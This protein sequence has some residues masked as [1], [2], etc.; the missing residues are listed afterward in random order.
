M[1]WT[2][3]VLLALAVG[4]SPFL[5]I[6]LYGT[7]PGLVRSQQEPSPI[8]TALG[9]KIKR[10][11]VYHQ[12]WVQ[13]GDTLLELDASDLI[14]KQKQLTLWMRENQWEIQDLT[15]LLNQPSPKPK[16]PVWK[17]AWESHRRQ[18]QTLESK[19]L[20]A[21]LAWQ[22]QWGL[23]Q[24]RVIPAQELEGYEIQKNQ[25][26]NQWK[27][28]LSQERAHWAQVLKQG[29]ERDAQWRQEIKALGLEQQHCFI[30][31]PI[32]GRI[33]FHHGFVKGSFVPAQQSIA[34]IH[35]EQEPIIECQVP[36]KLLGA[37][38]L[39]QRSR[40]DF[41]AFPARIWGFQEGVVVQIQRSLKA[42]GKDLYFTL[43]VKAKKPWIDLRGRGRVPLMTGMT[44]V[45][46]F[47]QETRSLWD[48]VFEKSQAWI[49]PKY[50]HAQ[51]QY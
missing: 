11:N 33:Q 34:E 45:A 24:D 40:L 49:N 37:V 39:G 38:H 19:Y 4:M 7:A 27:N 48:L 14:E 21:H 6:D 47:Y 35:P 1:Y 29:Q 2:I 3:L 9:A 17:M 20:D 43:R 12:Q 30:L 15:H 50:R 32:T 10:L 8:I 26:L 16:S 18:A 28:W 23:F 36:V 22:R 41:E 25:A 46:H 31:A 5:P 44:L 51:H 13:A 42:Q